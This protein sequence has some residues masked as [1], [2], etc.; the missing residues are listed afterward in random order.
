M[1]HY[2]HALCM[3]SYL[4]TSHH[5]VQRLL[6]R[7][8][9]LS[10]SVVWW[11]GQALGWV[12]QPLT[13]ILTLLL[14]SWSLPFKSGYFTPSPPIY[15]TGPSS[16]NHSMK[17]ACLSECR[18]DSGMTTMQTRVAGMTMLQRQVN[19]Y[20][21]TSLPQQQHIWM[22]KHFPSPLW[23]WWLPGKDWR[24]MSKQAEKVQSH[25][26]GEL[27]DGERAVSYTHLTLPTSSYV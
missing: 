10:S 17:V 23:W 15:H 16:A 27:K 1:Q 22:F 12:V 6:V 25:R 20:P 24:T 7:S 9:F 11:S 19:C 18:C 8:D 2:L 3:R 4:G 26:E 13:P 14:N 21:S 5:H